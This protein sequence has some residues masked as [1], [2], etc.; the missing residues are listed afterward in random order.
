MENNK[1]GWYGGGG[2]LRSL[3][4]YG[5][6]ESLGHQSMETCHL[7]RIDIETLNLLCNQKSINVIKK[8]YHDLVKHNNLSY[9]DVIKKLIQNHINRC[10]CTG[11]DF[12]E[13]SRINLYKLF[14]LSCHD[15]IDTIKYDYNSMKKNHKNNENNNIVHSL[16]CIYI[17]SDDITFIENECQKNII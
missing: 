8:D 11:F 17:L 10:F 13:I 6:G 3:I 5:I 1:Y 14:L 2:G 4:W 12:L 9:S 7:E 15:K 16:S